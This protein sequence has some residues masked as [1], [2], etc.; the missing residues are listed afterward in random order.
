MDSLGV[1][2]MAVVLGVIAEDNSD[3]EVIRAL[4]RRLSTKTVKIKKFTGQ[5]CGKI[6]GKCRRWTESLRDMGCTRMILMHDL[7]QK[8]L[9]TLREAIDEALAPVA[10][11]KEYSCDSRQGN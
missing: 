11:P 4:V 9:K 1:Q 6:I 5:G 7:D 8:S 10:N 3:V 2:L